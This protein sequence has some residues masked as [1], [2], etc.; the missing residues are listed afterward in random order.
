[1]EG[2]ATRG[3]VGSEGYGDP[4]KVCTVCTG[5]LQTFL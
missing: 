1:V 5:F 3:G 2:T 4:A